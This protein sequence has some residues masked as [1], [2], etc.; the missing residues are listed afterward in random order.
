MKRDLL[1]GDVF[2]FVFVFVGR[3]RKR[4]KALVWDGTVSACSP[5]VSPTGGSQRPGTSAATAELP[6]TRSELLLFFE[7]SDLAP[8]RPSPER[9]T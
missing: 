2:V 1:D 3:D 7:G 6:L 9:F 4:A 8:R 5:S